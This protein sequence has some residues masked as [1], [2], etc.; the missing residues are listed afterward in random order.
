MER[1]IDKCL[2][3]WKEKISVRL[4]FCAG[5]GRSERPMLSKSREKYSN[6]FLKSILKKKKTYAPFFKAHL[7]LKIYMRNFRPSFLSQSFR[8]KLFYF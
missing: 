8:E 1:K 3:E 6:I 7:I 5:Q 2:S 4:F